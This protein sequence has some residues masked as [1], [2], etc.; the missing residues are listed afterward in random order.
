MTTLKSGFFAVRCGW[1]IG[2]QALPELATL[3]YL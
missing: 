1:E 3:H 2:L